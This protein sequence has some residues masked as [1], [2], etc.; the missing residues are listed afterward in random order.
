MSVEI[1]APCGV[2]ST[3]SNQSP[4]SMTPSL[5]HFWIR[6]RTLLSAIRCSGPFPPPPPQPHPR[7]CS[8]AS[9]VLRARPTSDDR[10]SRDYGLGL[11]RTAR[12]DLRD[13]RSSDLPVLAHG[14][15]TYVPRIQRPRGVRR[16]LANNAADDVAFRF[17]RP[18]RHPDPLISRLNSPARTHPLVNA[19]LRPHG[20]P[21]HD[22]GPPWTANS[23]L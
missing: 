5:S 20:S 4:S 22:S 23:S 3:V 15:F 1:D 19:S 8:T 10:A 17:V 13:G 18:R 12:P 21:T 9:Q 6:R 7:P 2:R 11:P 16:R 14:E